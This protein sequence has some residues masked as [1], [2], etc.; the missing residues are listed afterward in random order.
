[1]FVANKHFFH[2][3]IFVRK[4]SEFNL[5]GRHDS[6]HND[7]QHNDNQYND[8]RHYDFWQINKENLTLNLT[9]LSITAV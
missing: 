9:T 6:E 3:V 4:D 5:H 2:R 8:I 1:M 7:I